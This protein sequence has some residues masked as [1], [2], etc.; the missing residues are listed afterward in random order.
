MWYPN[1]ILK[2]QLLIIGNLCKYL[3]PRLMYLREFQALCFINTLRTKSIHKHTAGSSQ[4]KRAVSSD[5]LDY[6]IILIHMSVLFQEILSQEEKLKMPSLFVPGTSYK[7]I[8]L[9][10]NYSMYS[11]TKYLFSGPHAL[12]WLF[13]LKHSPWTPSCAVCI[14]SKLLCHELA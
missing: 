2:D 3:S 10:R 13:S 5:M 11:Q 12:K 14:S 7:Y 8:V 6:Q 9:H 4:A 1:N